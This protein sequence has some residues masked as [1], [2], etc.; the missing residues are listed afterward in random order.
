MEQSG[1]SKMINLKN[2]TETSRNK[3]SKTTIRFRLIKLTTN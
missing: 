3:K 1:N 2:Y